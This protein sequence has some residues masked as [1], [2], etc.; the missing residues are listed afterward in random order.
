MCVFRFQDRPEKQIR[1]K[2]VD[3]KQINAYRLHLKLLMFKIVFACFSFIFYKI[4]TDA[5]NGTTLA[6]LSSLLIFFNLLL[7]FLRAKRIPTR[8]KKKEFFVVKIPLSFVFILAGLINMEPENFLVES[9]V[10]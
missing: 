7:R 6:L 4:E 10:A 2:I 9:V 8:E 3:L 5:D 1:Q